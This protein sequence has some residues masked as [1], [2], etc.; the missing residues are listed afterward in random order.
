MCSQVVQVGHQP[1]ASCVPGGG[2]GGGGGDGVDNDYDELAGV[3]SGTS[4]TSHN[5]FSEY[6][7]RLLRGF[8]TSFMRFDI[9]M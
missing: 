3:Q 8:S 2:G 7:P 6:I 5:D 4:H 9:Q 1:G